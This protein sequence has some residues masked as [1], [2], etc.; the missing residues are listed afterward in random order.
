[1]YYDV[2]RLVSKNKAKAA[3]LAPVVVALGAA[4]ASWAVTGE[5][6]A[7][8]I[9]TAVSGAILAGVGSIATWLTPAGLAEVGPPKFQEPTAP[10]GA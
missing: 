1:M 2:V 8:E 10:P 9:R 5:F 4:L 3:F 6:N 7:T